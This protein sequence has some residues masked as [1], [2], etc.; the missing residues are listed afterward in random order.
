MSEASE[1]RDKAK[2]AADA[3]DVEWH[4]CAFGV[5]DADMFTDR[6]EA[7]AEQLVEVGDAYVDAAEAANH[8]SR[9]AANWRKAAEYLLRAVQVQARLAMFDTWTEA[10]SEQMEGVSWA[11]ALAR[12][13]LR[14][15]AVALSAAEAYYTEAEDLKVDRQ[16]S[17]PVGD[18]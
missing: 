8:P 16:N 4:A 15:A 7:L 12:R 6:L 10:S 3:V 11:V 18:C 17:E 13:E 5:S 1:A 2:A 9:K 14:N